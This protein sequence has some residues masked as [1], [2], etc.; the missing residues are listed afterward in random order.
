MHVIAHQ[1]TVLGQVIVTPEEVEAAIETA[2]RKAKKF[3]GA[4]LVIQQPMPVVTVEVRT[5][6]K[7]NESRGTTADGIRHPRD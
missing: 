3:A 2:V 6:L 1:H 7:G 5:T 4:E